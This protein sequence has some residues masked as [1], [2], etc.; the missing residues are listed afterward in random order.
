MMMPI[1][2]TLISA[3]CLLMLAISAHLFAEELPR[4]SVEDK[5]FQDTTTIAPTSTVTA[6]QIETMN[7]I[8][9]EDAISMQPSL[10]VRK[11]FI[12]DPNGV[13]G[14]RGSNMFQ[15]H[16]SMVFSDGLP[17]HYHLQTRYSGAPRWSLVSPNEIE[18]IDVIYGP[19]SAEYAGNA[20][21]GV[22]N[23]RTKVPTKREITLSGSMFLQD[24]KELQTSD[25]YRGESAFMSFADRIGNLGIYASFNHLDND[26]QP[27]SYFFTSSIG[28]DNAATA[29]NGPETGTNNKKVS[30]YYYGDNGEERAQTDLFKLKLDYQLGEYE[31]RARV[32]YE[33]RERELKN[34]NSYAKDASGNT[35]WN[36]TVKVG[37]ESFS[38]SGSNFQE[39]YQERNSL[40]YGLGF[41]GPVARSD[42]LFDVYY[43]DFD[44][45]KDE[46]IRTARNPNDP[47]YISENASY[48]GRLT[49][50]EDTGW[51]TF[52]AKVGTETLLGNT[53]ARLSV[54]YHYD[55]YELSIKPYKYDAV[56]RVKGASRGNSGGET[57]T[58]AL[59][60]QFGYA[61]NEKIDV[62]VGLRYEDWSSDGAF[63]QGGSTS[64]TDRDETAW[65]PKLSIGYFP[66]QDVTLRYSVARA[67]RFPIVEELY[68]N[69][70]TGS[71]QFNSDPNLEPE[72]G[73]HHNLSLEKQLSK[74]AIKVNIFHEEVDDV[75][76]T[77][78]AL[79][80]NNDSITTTLPVDTV[81]TTGAEFI[82][83]QAELFH[84]LL[85][86]QF[87]LTYTDAEI[88]KNTLN[89]SIEGKRFP[90]IPKWRSNLG[91]TY[92]HTANIDL[93]TNFRYASNSYGELDNSD[94]A[95]EVF[96]AQDEYFFVNLKARW[97]MNASASISAGIDNV[98]N[99]AAYVYHP[100][101][102]RTFFTS[103]KYTF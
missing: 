53:K 99:E 61:V 29:V 2:N 47:D 45:I 17:I 38:I 37:A 31:L 50:A 41:S 82:F 63:T 86:M 80:N 30:G 48:N 60:A 21:G 64:A 72:D 74:G 39:R 102:S 75:I 40:L 34:L 6:E 91:F 18:K 97:Q 66:A 9:T 14:I 87:N 78:S 62:A 59:F 1:K 79:D 65:S 5:L 71:R 92:H 27:Q 49:D 81:K 22:V 12:G 84:P 100:W 58:Q 33:S 46:E 101:P 69:E 8:N 7:I 32:A 96:G 35:I 15:G 83:Q 28:S 20:M 36:G 16:R 44:I 70:S 90:R 23:I 4:I 3:F 57:E 77:F 11:R 51:E 55:N 42:W 89:T 76:F 98:F 95:K 85:D 26:G 94:T 68:R 13:I 19:F 10:V 56:N 43:S 88:T 25:E 54:G 73:I 52:D 103:A 67:V 93:T 24:Y